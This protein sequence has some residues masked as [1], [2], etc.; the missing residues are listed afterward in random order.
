MKDLKTVCEK[1]KK[2]WRNLSW[3]EVVLFVVIFI[4]GFPSLFVSWGLLDDGAFIMVAQKIQ[5]YI[6]ALDFNSLLNLFFEK[7]PGRFR[8]FYWIFNWLVYL[9]GGK[10]AFFHHLVHFVMFT[11]ICFLIFTIVKNLS[12]SKSAALLSGILFAA[13][14]HNIENWYRLG[15]QETLL[16]LLL[17]VSLYSLV[18]ISIKLKKK[19]P[20]SRASKM[21]LILGL[22]CLFFAYFTKETSIAVIPFAFVLFIMAGFTRKQFKKNSWFNICVLFLII[23]IFA[24]LVSFLFVRYVKSQ[25]FYSANYEVSLLRLMGNAKSIIRGLRSSYEPFFSLFAVVFLISIPQSLSKK[26]IFNWDFL[27]QI[28]FLLWSIFFFLIQIPWVFVLGRYFMPALAGLVIFWGLLIGQVS[29]RFHAFRKVWLG[30]ILLCLFYFLF[31][32]GIPSSNYARNEIFGTVKISNLL[33][34]AAREAPPK[35]V[36][37]FNLEPGDATIELIFESDLHLKLFHNRP[38]LEARYLDLEKEK[39]FP[40]GTI[41]ISAIA[42]ESFWRYSDQELFRVG[43]KPYKVIPLQFKTIEAAGFKGRLRS[44]LLHPG[45][46]AKGFRLNE[47]KWNW[48]IYKI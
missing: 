46:I 44:V 45:R 40:Q 35:S 32:N 31:R 36:V 19:Y 23:N 5:A 15:P 11:A 14:M 4:F 27:W 38:D 13:G 37:Y 34:L 42:G 26:K 21:T 22:L 1:I 20:L 10:S 2:W 9:I 25:G 17:M 7:E 6:A 47:N 28:L 39:E 16:T 30:L 24:G 48:R 29:R 33:G 18:Q 41:L 3:Q 12:H 8:P 43:F